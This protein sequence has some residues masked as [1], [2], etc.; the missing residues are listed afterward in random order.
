M[1]LA[2]TLFIF[3]VT[4][5]LSFSTL[6]YSDQITLKNGDTLQGAVTAETDVYITW[7]SDNFGELQIPKDQVISISPPPETEKVITTLAK[8]DTLKGSIGLSGS[9]LG[10]NQ[11][12]DDLEL[13][14][15]F[16]FDKGKAAHQA[17]INYETLGQDD[18]PT[19]NDYG[20]AY[21]IDWLINDNWYLGNN[22]S[23]GADDKRQIDQSVS[24]GTNMGYQFWK[25]DTGHLSTEIGFAWINDTLFSSISDERLTWAWS[26]DYQKQLIKKVSFSYS[27]QLN[28]SIKDSENTQL[29]ADIGIIIPVT[30][31]LD[32]KITWDWSFD[33]QPE[34]GNETIDRKI[35]FGIN[36]TL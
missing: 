19:I 5:A 14:I 35:R 30:D 34:E 16:T 27:H 21:G 10:G 3:G 11:E 33:N 7:K 25:N 22:F 8:K 15:G 17:T 20:I 28:V 23:Y 12:R 32:T 24:F 18:E 4:I 13:D 1:N 36:Y 26:G 31:K 2:K 6:A 29:N 9:Y